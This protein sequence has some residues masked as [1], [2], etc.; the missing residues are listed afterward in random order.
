M[1]IGNS[2]DIIDQVLI[3]EGAKYK[4]N[5]IEIIIINNHIILQIVKNGKIVHWVLEISFCCYLIVIGL[6]FP[7]IYQHCYYLNNLHLKY[8]H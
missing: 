3:L 2:L 8:L 1:G 5:C 6:Y 7:V 4:G